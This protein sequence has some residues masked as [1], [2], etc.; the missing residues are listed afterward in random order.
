MTSKNRELQVEFEAAQSKMATVQGEK[1]T[2]AEQLKSVEADYSSYRSHVDGT[3]QDMLRENESLKVKC[4]MKEGEL[5]VSQC[6]C[7][8][9]PFMTKVTSQFVSS[10]IRMRR[11]RSSHCLRSWHN[12]K[13]KGNNCRSATPKHFLP[14]PQT[15]TISSSLL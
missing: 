8:A 7:D 11:Q 3:L 14:Y 1:E 13:M 10:L 2:L 4:S 12:L 5:E 9:M 6:L 15:T